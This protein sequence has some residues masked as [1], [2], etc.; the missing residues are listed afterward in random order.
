PTLLFADDVVTV[1]VASNFAR[2]AAE[3]SAA[4]TENS[5]VAVRISSG[6][7]GKLY[8]QIINGAPFD[9][10][11]SADAER[12]LLL[13]ESGLI[14]SGSRRSYAIGS[15]VVWSRD[16]R[17]RGKDCRQSLEQGEYGRLALANPAT[18]PYG[19]AAV[20]FLKAAGLW[21][22]ASPRAV[23]GENIAQTLQFVATGNA[24]LGL[25]AGSQTNNPELP[26]ATCTW[27]VPASS[28]ATLYQQAVLLKRARGNDGAQRFVEFLGSAVATEI[29]GRSGYRVPN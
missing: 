19:A 28:H 3:I 11:L 12:P 16:E 5:K 9:V 24:T 20:E 10:F 26:S 21:E 2:P 6:S 23:F 1:A 7:T 18:A 25:V 29:I 14:V 22:A 17:L 8:A 13:E 4:F 15:L 27:S